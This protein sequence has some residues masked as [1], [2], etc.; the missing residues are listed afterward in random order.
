[1]SPFSFYVNK[2]EKLSQCRRD[3]I[4]CFV[5]A[6][7]FW[8]L[9]TFIFQRDTA[10]ACLCVTILFCYLTWNNYNLYREVYN[11]PISRNQHQIKLYN[12]TIF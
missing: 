2:H 4:I 9:G 6:M 10:I 12:N 3:G 11:I 1:M 8:C 7:M 5:M